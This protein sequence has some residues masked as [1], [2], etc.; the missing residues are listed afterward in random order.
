[1]ATQLDLL[2]EIASKIAKQSKNLCCKLDLLIE[3][4]GGTIYNYNTPELIKVTASE[5]YSNGGL[6]NSITITAIGTT[7][8]VYITTSGST[9]SI[10]VGTTVSWTASNDIPVNSIKIEDSS[11]ADAIVTVIK[12][13]V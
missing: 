1:M 8:E 3:A 5:S 6:E 13:T 7:G 4:S 10:P 12:R 9:Y 2:S 11:T